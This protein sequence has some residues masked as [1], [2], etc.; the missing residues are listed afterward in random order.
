MKKNV[1]LIVAL[2]CIMQLFAQAPGGAP[3]RAGGSQAAGRFYGKVVDAANKGVD[4]ASIT[5]IQDRMDTVTRQ[6]KEVIVG[7]ML[8][9]A[10]GEFSI[11]NVPAFGRYKLRVT[12][13]GFKSIDQPV[14]FEMPNRN[15]EN[16]NPSGMLS[17]LDKD[18]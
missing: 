14:S 11:E 15:G 2:L 16:A 18:L 6:R 10:N 4:A 9:S 1:T 5:L 3:R 17:A 7:G 8:T 13:I 12:G